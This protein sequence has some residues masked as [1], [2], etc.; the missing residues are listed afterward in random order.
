MLKTLAD[1]WRR[2]PWIA[3]LQLVL[4]VVAVRLVMKF[5]GGFLDGMIEGFRN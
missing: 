4:A 5:G 2:N 3:F 1:H